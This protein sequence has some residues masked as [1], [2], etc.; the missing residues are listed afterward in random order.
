MFAELTIGMRPGP[1]AGNIGIAVIDRFPAAF[2]PR[3]HKSVSR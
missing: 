3:D 2:M 1:A